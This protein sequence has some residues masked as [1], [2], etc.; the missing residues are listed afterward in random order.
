MRTEPTWSAAP[1]ISVS[2]VSMAK[3]TQQAENDNH[4][5]LKAGAGEAW[6]VSPNGAFIRH[7]EN[8]KSFLLADVPASFEV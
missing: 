6:I 1:D 4:F 5:L 8:H 2:I 3:S 7:K